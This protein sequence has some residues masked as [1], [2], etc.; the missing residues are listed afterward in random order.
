M[1]GARVTVAL[2][3]ANAV[4]WG[5]PAAIYI[6]LWVHQYQHG[7]GSLL[8]F[9]IGP[10]PFCIGLLLSGVPII[11]LRRGQLMAANTIAGVLL[12]LAIPLG[13]WGVMM[14]GST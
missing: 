12:G 14:L 5:A 9:A 10:A 1:N 11:L 6:T 13:A 3:I 7:N 8:L 2:S 4:L